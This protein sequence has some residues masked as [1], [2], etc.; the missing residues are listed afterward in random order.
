M[1]GAAGLSHNFSKLSVE[2]GLLLN[3]GRKS[4]TYLSE[5]L[6]YPSVR[7]LV[8]GVQDVHP[9][10]H[11][12]HTEPNLRICPVHIRY[13]LI[14]AARPYLTHDF[15]KSSI[16]NNFLN[17]DSININLVFIDFYNLIN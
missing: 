4:W 15:I 3:T 12:E 1:R 13:R 11:I 16:I 2:T 6:I 7:N 14:S 17:I 9:L 5:G 10:E 8:Q